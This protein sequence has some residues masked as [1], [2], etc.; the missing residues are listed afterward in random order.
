[1][2]WL[3]LVKLI[4]IIT[5]VFMAVPLYS[6]VIVNERA[7]LGR[8]VSADV[9]RYMENMIRGNARRCYVFQLTV[10][11]TGL[12]LLLLNGMGFRAVVGNTAVGIKTGALVVLMALLSYVHFGLQPRIDALLSGVEGPE[13]PQGIWQQMARL[14][15]RRKRSAAVC[16]FLLITAVIFAVQVY[17]VFPLWA[18]LVL[19]ALTAL[20]VRHA[21]RSLVIYGWV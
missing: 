14:R 5:T 10:L 2:N 11:L 17:V 19:V 7:R 6:L 1:M 18:N 8:S 20:F 15:L 9:D 13:I 4:H 3:L 12:I 21:F 16:L